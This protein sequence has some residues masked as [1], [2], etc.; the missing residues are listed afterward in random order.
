MCYKPSTTRAKGNTHGLGVQGQARRGACQGG[1]RA[2]AGDA[3]TRVSFVIKVE[4]DA[5][6]EK[7]ALADPLL[8]KEFEDAA[9]DTIARFVEFV[10]LKMK[11][12]DQAVQKLIDANKAAEVEPAKKK[13]NSDIEQMRGS[14]QQFGVMQVNRAW[15]DLCKKKKEYQKYK[16][17]IVVTIGAAVAGLAT[18]IAL[19]ATSPW[20]GGAS[21]ALSIIGM[22]K[23]GVVISKESAAAAMELETAA[24][25]LEGQ[26]KI[27]AKIWNTNKAAAHGA[28][29]GAA[30]VK[31]FL[32]EAPP[33]IK[34]CQ[35][36]L[37]RCE[38]K[39][40]GINVNNHKLSKQMEVMKAGMSKLESDFM[41]EAKKRLEK[42]PS[43]KGG[44]QIGKVRNQ[45]HASVDSAETKIL[46]AQKKLLQQ[47]DR[48]KEGAKTVSNLKKQ[49]DA[50]AG[51]R[52]T[53]YK[54]IDNL[55]LL[56]DVAVSGLSGNSL[57][58]GFGDMASTFGSA[59]AGL[60]IDRVSK[61][62]LEGTF[63]E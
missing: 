49:V 22:V 12:T 35:D 25:S 31:Q 27:V 34:S 61:A 11:A 60:G 63:L 51:Y 40:N 42:H 55:L 33:N 62:A 16:I 47:V 6:I 9:Q 52:G 3:P 14:A 43:G 54:F 18:S 24:R 17:K 5:K 48:A 46:D 56:S 41:G 4:L 59:V 57:V 36:W 39:L 23:S 20:T 21:A 53:A 13:M 2:Q 29:V 1:G 15:D 38:Q 58:Q 45:F 10:G 28:E 8:R 30:I 44:A 26:L 37:Y 19:M 50:L 7:A 32:G